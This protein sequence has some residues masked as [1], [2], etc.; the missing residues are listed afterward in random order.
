MQI[1]IP[2]FMSMSENSLEINI[3]KFLEEAR[4][5]Q[6]NLVKIAVTARGA[7]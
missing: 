6:Q 3:N 7:S 4:K 2:K 1:K 5:E